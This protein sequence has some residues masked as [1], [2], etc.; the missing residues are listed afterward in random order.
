[1]LPHNFRLRQSRDFTRVR[2][3]GRS[4][5]NSLAALY[6]LPSRST[7]SLIGFSVSKRVGKASIRNLVKRR[8]REAVRSHLPSIFPGQH[9]VFIARPAA[10]TASFS[11]ICSAVTSL[12]QRAGAEPKAERKVHHA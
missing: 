2:R 1:M 4:A 11:D 9:L 10:A 8:F 5:S 12:L 3:R 7:S 6:V